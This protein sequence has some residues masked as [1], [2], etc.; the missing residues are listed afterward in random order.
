MRHNPACH[1]PP[2]GI[3]S[4]SPDHDQAAHKTFNHPNFDAPNNNPASSLF[5]RVSAT[6]TGQEERRIFVGLKLLW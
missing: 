5:G 2:Q 4:T 3:P 6:Q 1:R